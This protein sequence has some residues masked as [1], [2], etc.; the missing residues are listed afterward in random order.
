MHGHVS[1]RARH[2][3]HPP[4]FT[5]N[6]ITRKPANPAQGAASAT[7]VSVIKLNVIQQPCSHRE[8]NDNGHFY[9]A[10]GQQCG[11][12]HRKKPLT[13]HMLRYLIG[14]AHKLTITGF[15]QI[16]IQGKVEFLHE[17]TE[18]NGIRC[19]KGWHN[20]WRMSM[21]NTTVQ[22]DDSAASLA[23]HLDESN[24][25]RTTKPPL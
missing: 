11:T 22:R 14:F 10:L 21:S 6:H 15:Q 2:S 16:D 17:F 13:S 5:S 8:L 20:A 3:E 4:T 19:S 18:L 23:M 7:R 1:D 24:A 12:A 9:F 25:G